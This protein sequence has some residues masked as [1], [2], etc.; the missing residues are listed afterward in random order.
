[1]TSAIDPTKPTTGIAYTQ[2]VRDNFNTAANEIGA[3]QAAL[4]TAQAD[5]QALKARTMVAASSQT[6]NPPNTTST[7]FV[8]AGID[9]Q[10]TPHNS[11]RGIVIVEGHLGNVQNGQTSNVQLS[12]GLG[13]SPPVGTLIT[14]TDGQL[15]GLPVSIQ[16]PRAN[17]FV[18][19]TAV[20]LLSNLVPGT[21]YWVDAAV[22]TLTGGTALLSQMTLT[23][24]E[25]L[26]PL[27]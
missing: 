18:P 2:D 9:I 13:V 14:A 3:L 20:A 10:F 16:A 19:F 7:A 1:M 8:T 26:D 17:G 27:P 5:I 23:A 22:N 21:L 6:P 12:Y 24:F 4:A 15:V 25:I 11:T